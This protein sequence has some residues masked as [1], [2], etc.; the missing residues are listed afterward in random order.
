MKRLAWLLKWLFYGAIF[1]T[2]FAFALN[3]QQDATLRFFFGTQWRMPMALVILAAF[4]AGLLIGIIAMVP[5]WWKQRSA[6]K[7]L[8]ARPVSA[9][10]NAAN[11]FD[12][13]A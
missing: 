11:Q 9:P 12:H 13:G 8:I 5:R 3:N 10:K 7:R 2:F 1:F 4:A 6:A